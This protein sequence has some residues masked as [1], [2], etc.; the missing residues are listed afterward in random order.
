MTV[1][2]IGSGNMSRGIGTR[3]ST[4]KHTLT[5]YDRDIKKAQALSESLGK[6]VKAEVLG[7]DI[8]EEIVI[9]T[10]PYTAIQEVIE[11]N[12]KALAG[13]ILIDISNPVDF[14]TFQLIPPAE[15]S[16]AEEIAKK[17]PEKSVLVKA[18][19]TTF[20]GTLTKGNIS[21]QKLDVF[22][23]TDDETARKTVSTLV[24]DSGMRAMNA[25]K[26]SN[27]RFLEGFQL[28]HMTMQEALGNTWMTG[29]KIL[30]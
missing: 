6:N 24:E 14:Q 9:F 30:P 7:K 18:F 2:I 27:A 17:L 22:I 13:K 28:L 16:G 23:A 11:S 12:K 1:A 20:A 4:S 26:L 10:L 19:N 5:I 8:P 29:I 15:S 3:I 25:G 21:G